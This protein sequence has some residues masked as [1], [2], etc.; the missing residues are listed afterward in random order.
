[1]VAGTEGLVGR[2]WA[3]RTPFLLAGA[4][5]AALFVYA[6]PRLNSARIDEAKEAASVQA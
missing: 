2:E 1:V 3:L 4:I 5:T 6:L